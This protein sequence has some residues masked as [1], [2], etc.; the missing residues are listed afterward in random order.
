M[1]TCP[2]CFYNRL[3]DPPRDYNICE[4]CGTEFGNDDDL[5]SWEDLRAEWINRGARWF[6]DRPPLLW[7]PYTQLYRAN[8]ATIVP[9]YTATPVISGRSVVS[10]YLRKVAAVV[11]PGTMKLRPR[12]A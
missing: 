4:C 1:F 9:Y 7:N 11:E 10:Q 8:V 2:V 12:A 3:Q 5:A 6:F